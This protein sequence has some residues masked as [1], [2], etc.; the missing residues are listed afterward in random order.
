MARK[1]AAVLASLFVLL[2]A[3]AGGLYLY[4]RSSLP[5]I[6]GEIAL[7]GLKARAEIRRDANGVAYISARSDADAWFALGFAHAQDRLWQM[8]FQRRMGAGRLSEV[9]GPATLGLDRFM[10]TL[11][12]YRVAE[13][14][15]AAISEETREALESYAAGVNAFL[16]RR[17]GALPPEFALLRYKPEK[18]KPADS[19]V[20]GRLMAL[21]LS[22]NMRHEILR[23]RL[24][25]RVTPQQLGDLYPG[26]PRRDAPTTLAGAGMLE[27]VWA[28][29]PDGVAGMGASNEWAVAG[30]H[31]ATGKP[32]LAND[33]HLRFGMPNLWYL[34][35]IEAPGLTLAGATAPGVPFLI[36]G[37][38]GRVAWA[39]T[40]TH[41]DTQDLFVERIDPADPQRYQTPQG[42][43]PFETR[44]E[45]IKVRGEAPVELTVRSTRH[46]PVLSDAQTGA[47][48]ALPKGMP[49]E[50]LGAERDEAMALAFAGLAP[51]DRTAEAL[52]RMNRARGAAGFVAALKDFHSPQQNVAFADADGNIGLVVAGR[53]PLRRA[54]DGR[55]PAPGWNGEY[56]WT[57]WLPFDSL[58]QALNPPSG[59]IVSANN[60][61]AGDSAL[62]GSDWE[63]GYR[64]RRIL[65]LL[66]VDQRLSADAAAQ[67]QT[68]ALSMA[69]RDLL[70]LMTGVVANDE[71]GRRAAAMLKNWDGRMD[72]RR[73][74]PLIFSAW[75]RELNRA[76]YA[77][78]LG[79][80]FADYWD[81]RPDVVELMLTQRRHWCDDVT[82]PVRETCEGRVALALDRALD[83]LAQRHG[84][85]PQDWR[86]GDAHFA[87]FSHPL[88]GRMPV[89]WRL[90]DVRLPSDGDAYTVNRGQT[91]ISDAAEPFAHVHGAGFRAVYDLADL[92]ASRFMQAAGQSGH[93]L[94]PFYA[95]LA[96]RWRDGRTIR[97]PQASAAGGKEKLAVL[98]LVPQR[99]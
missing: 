54:G 90:S 33:P 8:D 59:A 40:T 52:Y 92:D 35:R 4:L 98:T 53:V 7:P 49:G 32:I 2:L 83:F 62:L 87:K 63:A 31:T 86:W 88:F 46:G 16:S 73:P 1:F 22:D 25:K 79:P 34:A 89:L 55:L 24:A 38:N 94:S 18:W 44:G 58:P 91:A 13:Q 65:D 30:A 81:L 69:A 51:D 71:R 64:A 93:P 76:L 85:N 17:P 9:M 28:A 75:L 67:M 66:A 26:A 57:G 21:T 74:E 10:R 23:A 61:P 42:P 29:L 19:L 27:R 43:R 95:N 11:G 60:K 36:L 39:L 70:P 68:D 12:L 50:G 77:D 6:E 14:N 96:R 15:L 3:A 20:W 78:E 56:D 5:Q 45:T 37:H 84:G 72:R 97:V 80:L 47:R 99:R 41:G 48:E 82:T